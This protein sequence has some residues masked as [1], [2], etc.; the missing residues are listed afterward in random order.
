MAAA[1]FASLNQQ[2][3]G[4]RRSRKH[5]VAASPAAARGGQPAPAPPPPAQAQP[6][7]APV[8]AAAAAAAELPVAAASEPQ[9]VAP[10][11]AA[12]ASEAQRPAAAPPAPSPTS[13]FFGVDLSAL[14]PPEVQ[15]DGALF[16]SAELL[17]A[18]ELPKTSP[19]SSS[20]AGGAGARVGAVAGDVAAGGE[21]GDAEIAARLAELGAG[22]EA[23][24]QRVARASDAQQP[25]G[26][27]REV[28]ARVREAQVRVGWA[29]ACGEV[30]C[31]R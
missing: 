17:A 3:G 19:P 8:A 21:L 18:F 5:L 6:A 11:L 7:P 31:E 12:E 26:A 15:S 23:T 9:A 16:F 25:A 29:W 10:P 20:H 27:W 2:Q 28:E 30:R 4:R 22:L 13:L 14:P 1:A 24:L